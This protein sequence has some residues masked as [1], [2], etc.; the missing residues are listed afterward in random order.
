MPLCATAKRDSDV[1]RFPPDGAHVVLPTWEHA[2]S[3]KFTAQLQQL[4]LSIH[5]FR[6]CM[7]LPVSVWLCSAK[8]MQMP[9]P[10]QLRILYPS[11]IAYHQSPPVKPCTNQRA[12][13]MMGF[14]RV[15]LA[16]AYACACIVC[17]LIHEWLGARLCMFAVGD[18]VVEAIEAQGGKAVMFGTPIV[19]DGESQGCDGMRYSLPSRD[20]IADC[21]GALLPEACRLPSCVH[22]AHFAIAAEQPLTYHVDHTVER[23][24][25]V[26]VCVCECVFG[27]ERG[28][29]ESETLSL[30][31]RLC[32][33]PAPRAHARGLS[34]RR[35]D[36]PGGLRQNPTRHPHAHRSWKQ[37]ECF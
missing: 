23:C 1:S 17:V 37:R 20:L 19:S 36:Y 21:I 30:N 15:H 22:I 3:I 9:E 28:G 34:C 14:A 7:C 2:S 32:C 13:C 35:H 27:E 12:L 31:T 25:Y 6:L 33:F 24:G 26:F 5:A 11:G 10:N 29:A 4:A 8:G 18:A 16:C